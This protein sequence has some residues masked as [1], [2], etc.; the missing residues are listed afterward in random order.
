[1]RVDATNQEKHMASRIGAGMVVLVLVSAGPRLAW[2]IDNWCDAQAHNGMHIGKPECSDA[3]GFGTFT[4]M[5]HL[6]LNDVCN[7]AGIA[8]ATQLYADVIYPN[9]ATFSATT[10]LQPIV[11]QHGGGVGNSFCDKHSGNTTGPSN[12]G[13]N[14]HPANPYGEIGDYLAQKG[15]VVIFPILGIGPGTTPSV[16]ADQIVTVVNCIGNRTSSVQTGGCA[17]GLPCITDLVDKVAWSPTS[18]QN[19]TFVGHSAGAMAGLYLPQKFGSSLKAMILL[20]PSKP[21]YS[22]TAPNGLAGHNTHVI[23]IYPD[24]YGPFQN[25]QNQLFRLGAPN[26]CVGGRCEGGSNPGAVC[27]PTAAC[28]GGF[29][30]DGMGCTTAS[31]C[32]TGTTGTCTGPA[33][34]AGAWVPLGLREIGTCQPNQNCHVAQHCTALAGEYSWLTGYTATGH[35]TYC[36]PNA[37]GANCAGQATPPAGAPCSL[38]FIN[39]AWVEPTECSRDS[40]CRQGPTN[41]YKSTQAWHKAS[42]YNILRRYL[43]AYAVCMGGTHG[44]Y[45][46]S[47]VNG[48]D[49]ELDDSGS[50]TTSCVRWDGQPDATCATYGTRAT[51]VA[52]LTCHWA[53]GECAKAIRVNNGTWET[54]YAWHAARFYTAAEGYDGN[55]D[56]WERQERMGPAGSTTDPRTIRCQSGFGTW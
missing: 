9:P 30:T 25:S 43:T 14:G 6:R 29:C 4:N 38:E 11:F 26:T 10:R 3:P 33:P 5:V 53:A 49:R 1:M 41:A 28:N 16:D 2:A 15:A 44:T 34:V 23:H 7:V 21:E 50:M 51:C 40:S 47:W 8:G 42:A 56:F 22:A 39:G 48:K 17:G 35:Q 55:G 54:E 31:Q 19:I 18:K 36:N 27:G 37:P 12:C 46:Q 32:G 24:W 52:N 45:Y 20:D 13:A